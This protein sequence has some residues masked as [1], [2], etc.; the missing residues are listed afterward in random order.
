MLLE[1]KNSVWNKSSTIC[2]PNN[3]ITS[4][5]YAYAHHNKVNLIHNIDLKYLSVCGY[6]YFGGGIVQQNILV[7]IETLAV[8]MDRPERSGM[9]FK[10]NHNSLSTKRQEYSG[11]I[12]CKKYPH[13]TNNVNNI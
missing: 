1:I 11:H 13:A 10:L 6:R 3:Q 8:L 12:N 9:N 5:K 4:S 2:P 7:I